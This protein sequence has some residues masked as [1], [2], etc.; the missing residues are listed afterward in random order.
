MH[1]RTLIHILG[2]NTWGGPE[3][4][5]YD[6]CRHFRSRGWR[7]RVVTRDVALL[8]SRFSQ[9]GIS[10]R[11]APLR[12]YPDVF[13]ALILRSTF[14]KIPRGEGIVHVHN[15]HDALTA[16][17]A[18]KLSRR[19]DIRIVFTRH[20]GVRGKDSW[21]RSFIYRQI[22]AFLFVSEFSRR[23][24]LAAWPDGNYPFDIAHTFVGYNSFFEEHSP[25][26]EPTRGPITALYHGR[27]KAGKGL[28]TLIDALALLKNT[29]M[30]VKIAG[31]GDP[32]YCDALRRRAV[33]RG[34]MEKI[35]WV[36]SNGDSLQYIRDSHFGV[37]PSVEPEAFGMA[38]LEMMACGRP[39]ISTL[40]GGEKEFLE[41]GVDALEVRPTDASSLAEAMRRLATDADL[42]KEMGNAAAG[43][44]NIRFS[45][46]HFVHRLLPAYLTSK[47]PT[48]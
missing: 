33:N 19:S 42:R 35:D 48:V 14:L 2:S 8:D 34:V 27:L 16:I 40:T 22:D 37:F 23:R 4:Y 9:A 18:R 47:H 28:E 24:F 15:H 21:L 41:A 39:Q 13:S 36:K 17:I 26:E 11:H 7:V 12:N 10:L 31:T 29:R 46:P 45:W 5:A 32:D 38:G 6:I 20:K 44:Y 25:L 43:K 1:S 3:R 30:R